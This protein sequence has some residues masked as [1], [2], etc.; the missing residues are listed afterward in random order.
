MK[1]NL[2]STRPDPTF[3]RVDWVKVDQ[4]LA[5]GAERGL[6]LRHG[7][8]KIILSENAHSVQAALT[9]PNKIEAK[10]DNVQTL[11]FYLNDQMVDLAKPITVV[12]NGKTRFEGQVT[13][14]LD[15]MLKDQLFLRRGWRYFTAVLDI[16][17]APNSST[18][19]PTTRPTVA[20]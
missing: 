7:S 5:A 14:S 9:T 8:G 1:V 16:D 18:T 20:T 10:T 2:R 6:V 19:K 3:N 4:P 13:P 17:L 15:A 12:V 11:R